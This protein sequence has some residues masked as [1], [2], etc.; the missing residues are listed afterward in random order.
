MGLLHDWGGLDI[1]SWMVQAAGTAILLL[2]LALRIDRW[3][4]AD[5]R[6][7]FLASLL[8]YCVIFNHKAERQSY[9][10]ALSGIVIWYLTAP[11]LRAR[12]VLFGLVYALTSLLSSSGVPGALKS[13]LTPLHRQALPVTL[14]WLVM[15]AELLSRR[16]GPRTP[17]AVAQPQGTTPAVDAASDFASARDAARVGAPAP[18]T[19]DVNDA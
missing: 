4:E 14:V 18:P 11:R 12:D 6:R 16:R 19:F 10:I 17:E 8:V 5:F 13:G 1:A 2:P 9:V 15:Q 7:R 3:D